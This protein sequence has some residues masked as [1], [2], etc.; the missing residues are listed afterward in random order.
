M[1]HVN[2]WGLPYGAPL[3]GAKLV[4]P[5]AQLDG[6]SLLE[7][8]E[9][10]K[11]TLSAGVPTVWLGLLNHMKSQGPSGSAS[12]EAHRDRRLGLRRPR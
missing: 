10:E 9:S 11:V 8:F 5:G 3:V 2:A 4:F 6:A 1:F 7:L 12:A